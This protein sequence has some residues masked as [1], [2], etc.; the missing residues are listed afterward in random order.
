MLEAM[1]ASRVSAPTAFARFSTSICVSGEIVA[2]NDELAQR[3]QSVNESPYGGGWLFKIKLADKAE[4]DELLA[5]DAYA[6]SA[7]V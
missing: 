3:P 2:A 7:G 1:Q 4:L 6:K 5:R